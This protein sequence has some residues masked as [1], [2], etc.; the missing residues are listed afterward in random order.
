[1]SL[2]LIIEMG[3]KSALIA[4]AA[5]LLVTL[6]RSRSAADRAAVLRVGVALLLVLPLIAFAAPAL[7]V[8][9]PTEPVPIAVQEV[10]A[11]Q[12]AL[13][14][15]RASASPAVQFVEAGSS[16]WADTA[17]LA[18][19]A[20][21]SGLLLIGF[22]LGAG[23][24]TLR[25]WTRAS[26]EVTSTEWRA[27]LVRWTP[28]N[29]RAP[30]LLV[31]DEVPAPLSWGWRNPAILL[32]RDALERPEDADAILAHEMAHV[33]RGDWIALILARVTVALFWFNPLVWLLAR[34]VAQQAEEAADSH[35]LSGVDPAGYAQTLVSC[36]QLLVGARVPANG[37]APSQGAL[38]RRVK[39]VLEGRVTP[40]GSRWTVAAMLGV[41]AFA[42]PVA[43]LELIPPPAP[44]PPVAPA[45]PA[46][47]VAPVP[48]A[49]PAAPVAAVGAQSAPVA[50][51][52]P[53]PPTPAREADILVDIDE[54]AIEAAVEEV[55]RAVTL[56]TVDVERIA[57]QAGRAA[58]VSVRHAMKSARIAHRAGADAMA[59]GADGMVDGARH[60]DEEAQRLRNASYR[61]ELIAKAARRGEAVT[62]QELIDAIPE[63]QQGA[64][65][66]RKGAEEMRK[67]AKEMR[68]QRF[69]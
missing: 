53:T 9:N 50:P 43:A 56:A 58:E 40:S 67:S 61:D 26:E 27:A 52:P 10:A 13:P 21:L 25:R 34:E 1:M 55:T 59:Q 57:E 44:K 7:Q 51:T 14:D 20:Y 33:N 62:H 68:N 48:A 66:M 29:A 23:L 6:L 12:L 47:P 2:S 16:L 49:A 60:M 36:A 46:A 35:A 11:A 64:K 69:D 3:W 8:I 38:A 24:A 17:L 39:A 22:R 63:L 45:P 37:I 41:V 32:D 18:A 5:L 4:G 30:R 28:G 54:E 31:S 65:E 19:V 15:T 42:A